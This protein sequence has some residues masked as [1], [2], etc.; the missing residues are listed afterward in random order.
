MSTVPTLILAKIDH[1]PVVNAI[2]AVLSSGGTNAFVAR[3]AHK[4]AP[5]VATHFFISDMAA[6]Q[7][8]VDE[9]AAMCLGVLPAIDGEWGAGGVPSGAEAVA[10]CINGNMVVIPGYG[11]QDA[12]PFIAG[13]KE[14]YD[15]VEYEEPL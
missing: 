11:V 2:L 7:S 4:D 15:L 8:N 1:V 6:T 13:M 9:W 5:S 14:G 3:L 12:G 10:A